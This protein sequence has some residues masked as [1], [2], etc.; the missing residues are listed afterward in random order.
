MIKNLN[1]FII[2]P[3][4]SIKH[5]MMKIKRNGTR[6]LIVVKKNKFLLGTLSEGD[7]NSAL[8]KNSNL[9]LSIKKIYNKSPKKVDYN[10]INI[11][12]LSALFLEEQIGIMPVI[13][14]NNILKK[15]ISWNDIFNKKKNSSELKNIDV[16]IM[17]GG[18]GERLKPYTSILPKPLI[19]INGKPMLEHIILNLKYFNFKRFYL[20]L[21][22]QANLIKSYF[23][24]QKN[25]NVK[26]VIEPKPLGTVGGIR[27]LNKI[28]SKNFILSNCDTLFK[29]DFS[30]FY[31]FHKKNNYFMTLVVS[32]MQ[33]QFSYGFCRVNKEK[34]ISIDEKP[35]FNFIANAGLYLMKKDIISLIPKKKKF[36]LTDLI[37]KCLELKKSIGV[38]KIPSTSWRDLGALSDF[39]KVFREY[40]K[41][42]L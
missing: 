17:A 21:N 28:K 32:N 25:S 7:I 1:L 42:I 13:D 37:N 38:Y 39:N 15:I 16:I 33:H 31:N 14:N 3:E 29:I 24:T 41:N 34:L 8:I 9:Q 30:D 23:R 26:Y 18:K 10:N 11:D 2:H 19:P 5:A 35:K 22:H 40:D 4:D 27:F 12:K 20:I 6:T 36:D